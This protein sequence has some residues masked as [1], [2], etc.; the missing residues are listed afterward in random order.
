MKKI[1]VVGL[2]VVA[3][4]VSA[5]TCLA[6]FGM[7]IPSDNMVMPGDS[8][9]ITITVSFSHPFEGNGMELAKPNKFGVFISGRNQD[10]M[11]QLKQTKVMG[12]KA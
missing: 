6:H 11:G 10:L 12:H 7:V 8:R 5:G 9:N 3:F 4:L 2:I 1:V